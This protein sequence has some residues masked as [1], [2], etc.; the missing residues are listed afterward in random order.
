MFFKPDLILLHAPSVY[1]FRKRAL[2]FGPISDVVPST[3]VFEMYPVG[4]SAI[5]ECLEQNGVGVRI[6]NLAYRMLTDPDFDA[7]KM[8][9]KLNPVAFGIDLHWLVHAQGSMEIAA[10]C[11]KL[12]PDIPVILGGLASTYY[13]NELIAY[14]QIDFVF[15]GD[16]TETP[17][18]QLMQQLMNDVADHSDIPNLTW[19]D[20]AGQVHINRH[21]NV[22]AHVNSLT[23]NYKN[24]FKIALKYGDIKSMTAIHD[25]WQYPIVAMMTVRGCTQNCIICGGSRDGFQFYANRN[26]PAYRDAERIVDDIRQFVKFSNGPIFI[27]GDLNQHGKAYGEAILNGLKALA[28]AN[29]MVLELFNPATESFFDTVA[30]ALPNFNFEIS[31][32]SHDEA[33]RRKCGKFYTNASMEANIEWALARGCKKFDIFFMIGLSGQTMASALETVDYCEYLIKKFGTRIMPFTAPLAPFLDPG[34]IAYE[35]PDDYGYTI[36]YKGFEQHRT[37]MLNPSWKYFLNYQ[38]KWMNRDQIVDVTYEAG[39]RLNQVKYRYGIIDN[40][41]FE[42]VNHKISLARDMVKRIDTIMAIP[43]SAEQQQQL[44]ALELDIRTHSIDT[45]CAEKE[46]KWPMLKSGF[47]FFNIG[48]AI[49]FE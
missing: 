16:S 33:V 40:E 23:N 47:K 10:I 20:N 38:T 27:I 26:T 28:I 30:S 44:D 39:Q 3:P 12:H 46:I 36:L 18:L 17:L 41:T 6:I 21:S 37:A 25:W 9:Q 48:K 34:S 49:L 7:E 2:L 43:D 19:K 13:H 4:F 32:E 35:H 15:R 22:P 8:I 1:D 31:P 45:V 29:A 42:Q 14:P 5:A 11:K 24:L